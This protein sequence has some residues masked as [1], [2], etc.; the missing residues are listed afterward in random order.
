MPSSLIS[1]QWEGDFQKTVI[2]ISSNETGELTPTPAV[3]YCPTAPR[4]VPAVTFPKSPVQSEQLWMITSSSGFNKDRVYKWA[5]LARFHGFVQSCEIKQ[6]PQ[7]FLK[8]P[9][10]TV[11]LTIAG[12]IWTPKNWN[13]SSP[14]LWCGKACRSCN[15]PLH[16]HWKK[17]PKPCQAGGLGA[18]HRAGLG[19]SGPM[20]GPGPGLHLLR[21]DRRRKWDVL[22]EKLLVPHFIICVSVNSHVNHPTQKLRY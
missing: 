12:T 6:I 4:L 3:T 2:T 19:V 10:L 8:W 7:L 21:S 1:H 18:D 11:T 20:V 17:L 13:P 9:S 5:E 14:P 15:I 16:P 22:V